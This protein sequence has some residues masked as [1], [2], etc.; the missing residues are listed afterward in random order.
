NAYCNS[1]QCAP[2]RASFWSGQ[3]VHRVQ[4]WNN[5]GG[6]P[7]DAPT[8]GTHLENAGYGLHVFGK[9]D[10]RVGGHSLKARLTAWLRSANIK[11]PHNPRP[12]ATT[13]AS[14]N[15]H[16][17]Q[18]ERQMPPSPAAIG[19]GSSGRDL[20]PATDPLNP[21]PGGEGQS[22]PRTRS[23]G[24]GSSAQPPPGSSGTLETAPLLYPLQGERQSLPRTRSGV[25][26]SSAETGEGSS[27]RNLAPSN[28]PK[29]TKHEYLTPDQTPTRLHQKD[30]LQIDNT[31][32]F[33]NDYSQDDP[34]YFL[35]PSTNVPHPPFRATRHYLDKI[36]PAA[37][38]LPP[39]ESDLH[40]VMDYMSVTKNTHG[41][42]TDEE[43][44][45][46]RRHYFAMVAETDAM[47]GQVLDTLEATG[48]LNDT[49]IIFASD[50]GE[51]NM[52]HR[53]TLKNALYEASAR[54]P[55]IVAGPG[56]QQGV[57]SDEL[58]SLIDL[59]PTLMDIAG[60]D[61]P[62]GL[63]GVS[64]LPLCRGETSNRPN[65]VFSEYHSNFSN[66][67]I[68]MWRQGPW[69][70]IRYAGYDPQ[71][72][73]LDDDPEEMTNLAQS[74]PHIVQDLDARLES[75]V[76]FNQ[77]DTQAKTNDR[78]NYQ[79][80]RQPLTPAEIQEALTNSHQ[81]HWTPADD[82]EVENWLAQ[83]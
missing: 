28:T 33:L 11:R 42:F 15:L 19:E 64:L 44:L 8:F 22:L 17:L 24:E 36:D 7:M 6:L 53:Q 41:H 39:Y 2:S 1:P 46:I 49:Y 55:L 59:F 37:V 45:A 16:P 5:P 74:H 66:T 72:F 12:Q 43:I 83:S 82:E 30:W 50:H 27:A 48:Q 56:L 51:M 20:S 31:C 34:P 79:T 18:G 13:Y 52:E 29:H 61:H 70:Y 21:S 47:L 75:L 10:Y 23:G 9:T 76:D 63:D 4:A 67:G 3:Y 62:E 71:L 73:N 57:I 35:Y 32:Q 77:A 14:P 68:A 38:T 40:P 80:W 58:V 60:L 25:P 81:G 69:K 78:H 26:T 54:V 65:Y